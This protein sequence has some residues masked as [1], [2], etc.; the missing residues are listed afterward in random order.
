M[1]KD[2]DRK[3]RIISYIL[4]A[5]F[6][7]IGFPRG[8]VNFINGDDYRGILGVAAPLFLLIPPLLRLLKISYPAR[9]YTLVFA[10]LILAYDIGCVYEKFDLLPH[11]DKIAH[12]L[13]GILFTILGF[14]LYF[15]LQRKAAAPFGRD[16]LTA[17]S[18]A[19]FFSTFIAVVWEVIEFCGF[20]SSG[21]DFQ[22]VAATGVTDTMVDLL[23]CLA[24]S[25]IS[26]ASFILYVKKNVKLVT[27]PVAAEFYHALEGRE[28]A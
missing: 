6:V 12:F 1:L 4:M 22:R 11:Y 7:V 23:T 27:G 3:M 20:L 21:R 26:A 9:L 13:S 14:C 19:L 10:F 25:L 17:S 24:G 16:W 15:L 28:P 5:A 8:I 18:Y 2:A